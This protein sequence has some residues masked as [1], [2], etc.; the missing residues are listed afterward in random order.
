MSQTFRPIETVQR[1]PVYLMNDPCSRSR[2]DPTAAPFI[3]M[4]FTCLLEMLRQQSCPGSGMLQSICLRHFGV[5]FLGS[6]EVGYQSPLFPHGNQILGRSRA[7]ASPVPSSPGI[8]L[9]LFASLSI[10]PIARASH[11]V[12]PDSISSS[13]LLWSMLLS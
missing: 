8:L 12:C 13:L 1:P 11:V 2:C 10:S 3:A 9:S 7:Y 6:E 5:A 4:I